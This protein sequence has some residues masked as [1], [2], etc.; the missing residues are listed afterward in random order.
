MSLPSDCLPPKAVYQSRQELRTAINAWAST[1]GYAFVTGRSTRETS[2]KLTVTF[3]CNRAGKPAD[4]SKQGQRNTR[5]RGTNCPFSVLAKEDR[6]RGTWCIQHRPDPRHGAHNHGPSLSF[7]IP[8]SRPSRPSHR[9]LS[10]AEKKRPASL[11]S[12]GIAP[13][14]IQTFMQQSSSNMTTRQDIHN[15][16]SRQDVR[17]GQNSVY[18]LIN[19]LDRD[20]FWFRI[21]FDEDNNQ[22]K[23][24]LSAHPRAVARLQAHPDV[25]LLD[26]THETRYGMPL[27]NIIGFDACQK[28]FSVAFA[29]LSGEAVDDYMWA[30]QRLRS[31]Y[32]ISTMKLPSVILIDRCLACMNAIEACFPEST[33]LLHVW[34]ANEA[35]LRYCQ[36]SFMQ[37]GKDGII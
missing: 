31:L 35:V 3:T 19:Q 10:Q 11:A 9:N 4:S 25:L 27:L 23:S 20:G 26:C 37:P 33:P 14:E 12:A 2:G 1:R 24:F 30:L 28:P 29:F 15:Q 36:P 32:D 16:E 5:T 7:S 17:G 22:L 18:A 21:R 13:L 34:Q 8:P 6:R